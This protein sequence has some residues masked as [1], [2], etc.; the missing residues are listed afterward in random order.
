VS[1]EVTYSGLDGN[2]LP[3]GTANNQLGR[4]HI[5]RAANDTTIC[6]L[7]NN[8]IIPQGQPGFVA[9]QRDTCYGAYLRQL[10]TNPFVG[11]IREGAL[12]TPNIQRQLLLTPT[13]QY[14][15]S[16][17]EG[18]LGSS[19]YHGLTFRAEKR[20]GAGGLVGGHYTYSKNMTNVETLTGWLEG[21]AGTPSAGYQTNDLD[22]EWALSSFDIRH[23]VVVNFVYD[24]PFGGDAGSSAGATGIAGKLINGWTLNGVTTI[25]SG[26]PLAF[27][28][29]PNRSGRATACG[30]MWIQTATRGRRVGARS[31]DRWFNTA[32][33]SVPPHWQPIHR[34]RWRLATRRVDPDLRG[35]HMHNWNFAVT[36][37]THSTAA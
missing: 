29:T 36:K 16:S 23:R 18:Y 15:Q 24:L 31:T 27:T 4:E 17:Q 35:H 6:S 9:G 14:G 1:V 3:N 28:A 34:L 26:L 7:T 30:R 32:C 21:G 25:Q 22:G 11:L 10:V 37:T 19:R 2:H 5:D 20:F 12:S 8:Q 13:P 33:F